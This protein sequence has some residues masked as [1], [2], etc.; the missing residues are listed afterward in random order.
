MSITA[1]HVMSGTKRPLQ[2]RLSLLLTLVFSTILL[3]VGSYIG[4]EHSQRSRQIVL[5][6]TQALVDAFTDEFV[7]ALERTYRP[8]NTVLEILGFFAGTAADASREERLAQLPLLITALNAE[9]QVRAIMTAQQDG[10]FFIVRSLRNPAALLSYEAPDHTHYVVDDIDHAPNGERQTRRLF[11]DARQQILAD[12]LL[13]QTSY[14]PRERPWYRLAIERPGLQTTPPYR[15]FQTNEPGLTLARQI[16][17]SGRVLAADI[18]LAELSAAL[19]RK[20]ITPG[21]RL[22]LVDGSGGVLAYS[23]PA[24]ASAGDPYSGAPPRLQDAVDSPFVG[25]ADALR[26]LRNGSLHFNHRDSQWMALI[27]PLVPAREDSARIVVVVPMAELMAEAEAT[28]RHA[29]GLTAVALLLAIP[30]IWLVSHSITRPL[31]R[32]VEDAYRIRKFDFSRS[33]RAPTS[34]LEIRRLGEAFDATTETISRFLKLISMLASETR[35]DHLLQTVNRE[36]LTACHAEAAILFMLD[37]EGKM[38]EA[39][40]LAFAAGGATDPSSIRSA[41]LSD[42]GDPLVRCVAERQERLLEIHLGEATLGERFRPLFA[43]LQQPALRLLLLPLANREGEVS[44]VQCLVF[45]PGVSAGGSTEGRATSTT[46][47]PPRKHFAHPVDHHGDQLSS[48]SFAD[49]VAFARSLSGFA[50]VTIEGRY[51]IRMQKALLDSFIQL[52]AGAIDAKS[53]YTG[54]HCQRVPILTTMLV[55][56][57]CRSQDPRFATFSLDDKVWEAVHIA[58]W[59]H[60]CGKVTTPEYVVDKATKLE[61]IHDRIHE[62]RMRFEVLKRDAWIDYY[63]ELAALPTRAC[64]PPDFS[65]SEGPLQ[66]QPPPVET[67]PGEVWPEGSALDAARAGAAR[68]DAARAH[69]WPEGKESSPHHHP[70]AGI[71]EDLAAIRDARLAALDDDFAFVASC[72]LG[73]EYL[74]PQHVDRLRRIASRTW[75]R[76]LDDTLGVS[77]E[78]AQRLSR[79]PPITLP[80]MEPLLAD[81]PEHLIERKPGEE[82][83]ADRF[84]R[85]NLKAPE[86]KLNRGELHNLSVVRGTLTDEERFIINDHIVQTILMLERLPFPRHLREVPALAGGHHEKMDGTGYPLGLTRTQMPLVAR[87]MAIADIFEALT[88]SDRPYKEPKTL[89]EALGIME[90]MRKEQHIDSDLFDLFVS[91]GVCLNYARQ[92]LA[93]SQI[94]RSDTLPMGNRS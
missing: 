61:T 51:L 71:D 2:I 28:L 14:D 3:A 65:R 15:Y 37:N 8:I 45:K 19:R 58:C 38:L 16:D 27:R 31:A 43:I 36:T 56:A 35:F 18:T 53:P 46:S 1:W 13:E 80:V 92:F 69:G 78:E 50:A 63:R 73:S 67:Q 42:H 81:R 17:Q 34:L 44:G 70:P 74:D 93:D 86:H 82:R 54:G 33:Q 52:L 5:A 60:D 30:L 89:G 9:P 10:R 76:T 12:R 91:S 32:L 20:T 39:A 29:L 66:E 49:R 25:V 62:I 47:S 84:G 83:P 4:M 75:Q 72:N 64:S 57:A 7:L 6:Q 90:R 88:A 23:D 87:A 77:W 48:T 59:L 40:D 11:L 26:N 21:T 55:E 22:A 41:A 94:D 68:P 24:L 85:F 79:R